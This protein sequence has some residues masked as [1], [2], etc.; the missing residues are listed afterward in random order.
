[1]ENANAPAAEG[2]DAAAGGAQKD[3]HINIKVKA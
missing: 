1:M 2:G 3:V